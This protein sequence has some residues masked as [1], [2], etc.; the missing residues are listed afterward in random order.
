MNTRQSVPASEETIGQLGLAQAHWSHIDMLLRR[1][2]SRL[3]YA[4]EGRTGTLDA[5]LVELRRQLREPVDETALESLLSSLTDAVRS[6]DTLPTPAVTTTPVTPGTTSTASLLLGLIDRLYLDDSCSSRL[7]TVRQAVL[8]AADDAEL[9][10][11]TEAIAQLVNRHH[12]QLG[13]Q[14]AAAERLLSHVTGQL[15]ELAQ[16]LDHA[17]VDRQDSSGARAELDRHLTGEID[18]LGS[19]L[20][21]ASDMNS[22]RQ[23]LQSRLSTITSHLKTF[24]DREDTRER[25]WQARSELMNQRIR[26]LERSAHT[27][28]ASLR[29]E[30]QLASTDPLTGLANRLVFEQRMALACA[31]RA[32]ASAHTCLLVLDIDHFKQINDR[33]GHAA[34]DRALRIVA[35]QLQARLRPDDLL[36]RFGGEEFV[37]VLPDTGPEEG[38][39]MAEALRT[40]IEGIG[41]RGQQQPVRITLSCGVTSLQG[42][43]TPDTAFDRADRA[44]YRAKHGGRNRCVVL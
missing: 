27:M 22:L 38:H 41:F 36:A 1:L 26:E 39:A 15:D 21:H 29:Q 8:A 6:L 3:A 9:A 19:H 17:N 34:G 14:R 37:A 40:C 35:E 10:V 11:Q 23:E 44:L 2:A 20:Q 31:Q 24:R 16:Y 12:R 13:E 28:E 18:A 32:Q 42:D 43:D 33:F 5:A 25:D 7:D 30:R 4:A